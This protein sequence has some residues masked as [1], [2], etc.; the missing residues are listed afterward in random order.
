MSDSTHHS[1]PQS[2]QEMPQTGQPLSADARRLLAE[3]SGAIEPSSGALD[4]AALKHAMPDEAA[5]P[6]LLTPHEDAKARAFADLLD[7]C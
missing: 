7:R 4:M 1:A 5:A 3:I 6:V 2:G